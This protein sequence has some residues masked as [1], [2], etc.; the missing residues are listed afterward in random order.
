MKIK[1]T[2]VFFLVHRICHCRVI[3][4]FQVF[5]ILFHCKPMEACE[6]ISQ[7]LLEPGSCNLDHALSLRCRFLMVT[8]KCRPDFVKLEP[9]FRLLCIVN[10]AALYLLTNKILPTL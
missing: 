3:A 7:E 8:N 5:F 9:F 2:R 6:K 10:R 1:K 4:L